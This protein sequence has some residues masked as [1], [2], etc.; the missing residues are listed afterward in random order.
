[1][2]RALAYG[3]PQLI[4]PQ[5]ADHFINSAALQQ[6]GAGLAVPPDCLTASAVADAAKRLLTDDEFTI[7]ATKIQSEI[8]SADEA[9]ARLI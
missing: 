2:G 1:V 3:L 9:L 7:V 4:L 8:A 5:G 6:A